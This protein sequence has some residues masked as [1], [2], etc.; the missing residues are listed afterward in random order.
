MI[1]VHIWWVVLSHV[2]MSV[3]QVFSSLWCWVWLVLL[4]SVDLPSIVIW[5][6]RGEDRCCGLNI[7]WNCGDSWILSDVWIVM[8][9]SVKDRV[10]W[11]DTPWQ[12]VLSYVQYR[13]TCLLIRD[14]VKSV[15][16]LIEWGIGIV[17]RPSSHGV[18]GRVVSWLP[19]EILAMLCEEPEK[20]MRGG[21]MGANLISLRELD[22]YPKIEPTRFSFISTKT[23]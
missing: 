22:L 6:D 1:W 4:L 16:C 10:L 7:S 11:V 23:I 12:Q 8:L 14:D 13:M 3:K 5:G 2:A 20:G 19:Q 15:S 18:R 17:T 21:W 9:K